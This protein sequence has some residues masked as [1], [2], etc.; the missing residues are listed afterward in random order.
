MRRIGGREEIETD[1]R[2][3]AATNRNL[4]EALHERTFRSDLYYRL[5]VVTIHLPPLRQRREDVP[6]LA[7]HCLRK[8][9]LLGHGHVREISPSA[10]VCLRA[11][12][13]PGN[14]RELQNVIERAIALASR[15]IIEMDDLPEALHP[16]APVE[17]GRP[18]DA[19][20]ALRAAGS[21]AQHVPAPGG[22]T[23]L[24]EAKDRLV[25][26]FERDYLVDLLVQ[27]GL[28]ITRAAA[29]AGCHRRTLYRMIHRH[30]L[31]LS[32]LRRERGP[33]GPT[34]PASAPDG[35]TV[36]SET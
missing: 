12:R 18:V 31:D 23:G 24:F 25:G 6:L 20:A 10:M 13:W 16:Q 35:G 1:V 26:D 33:G 28:N 27:H 9:Q 17:L 8:H 7:D 11:Y 22:K 34:P 15:P 36:H 21:A 5:N 32:T 4:E 19:T 29:A 2:I 3:I 30:G 14:V